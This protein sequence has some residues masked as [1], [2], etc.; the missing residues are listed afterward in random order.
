MKKISLK[1]TSKS[2]LALLLV[3]T[4]ITGV[5]KFEVDAADRTT[6]SLS[7]SSTSATGNVTA[8][9][10]VGDA[11]LEAMGYN[12]T[13]SIPNEI[14]LTYAAGRY[15]GTGGIG[16]SGIIDSNQKIKVSVDTENEAY[17]ILNGPH[18][19]TKDLSTVADDKCSITVTKQSWSYVEASFNLIDK[20]DDKAVTEW[21]YPSR[22]IVSINERAYIPIYKGDYSMTIPLVIELVEV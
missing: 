8:K 17:K 14:T 4:A 13:V 20:K 22:L 21:K 15:D 18:D 16:V 6:Y 10:T 5:M 2:I 11:D 9:F 19:F 12:T 7:D 3:C 1:K